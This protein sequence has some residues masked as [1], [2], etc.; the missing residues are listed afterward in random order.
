MIFDDIVKALIESG[1]KVTQDWYEVYERPG[2]PAFAK[3]LLYSCNE[4]WGKVHVRKEGDVYIQVI[5]KD[6]FNWKDRVAELRL[7]NHIEDAAG[8]LMWLHVTNQ[9]KLKEDLQFL[10]KYIQGLKQGK[11]S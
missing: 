9:E 3:E 2:R 6:V 10:S 5:S 4:F 1:C 8:G 7:S 11:K